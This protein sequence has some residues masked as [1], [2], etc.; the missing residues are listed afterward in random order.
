[1]IPSKPNLC[2]IVNP[3]IHCA[4]CGWTI[5]EDCSR[6]LLDQLRSNRKDISEKERQDHN[7]LIDAHVHEK[8]VIEDFCWVSGCCESY[9][10]T[11]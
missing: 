7:G 8:G 9:P 4:R 2:C 5:C 11:L 10:H 3:I 1:M 6:P